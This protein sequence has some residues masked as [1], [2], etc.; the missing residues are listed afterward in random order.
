MAAQLPKQ[1][2]QEYLQGC[3]TMSSNALLRLFW[4]F[5]LASRLQVFVGASSHEKLRHR[6]LSRSNI[7]Q[8]RNASR[9]AGVAQTTKLLNSSDLYCSRVVVPMLW[10]TL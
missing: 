3:L 9:T 6:Y 8:G 5:F 2:G 4:C 10:Q 7:L 1:P